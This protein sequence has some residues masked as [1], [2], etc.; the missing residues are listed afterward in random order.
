MFFQIFFRFL[1]KP[2]KEH[3]IIKLM[4]IHRNIEPNNSRT[5]VRKAC[6]LRLWIVQVLVMNSAKFGAFSIVCSV[7]IKIRQRAYNYKIYIY[8]K[9]YLT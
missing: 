7:F 6:N 8:T 1:L 4:F 3:I 2:A 5:K 9:K